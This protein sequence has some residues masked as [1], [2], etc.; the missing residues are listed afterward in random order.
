MGKA[1]AN[2]RVAKRK[3]VEQI[4]VTNITTLLHFE[5]IAEQ[6]LLVDASSSGFLMHINR[7]DLVPE[8]LRSNLNISI[9]EGEPV[10]MMISQMELEL[11]GKIART[12]YI[13]KGVFEVAVDFSDD[14]PEYW[15]ECLFDLL[16]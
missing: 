2:K 9:V 7:K 14:A 3:S 12:K 13:G 6:A 1:A 5:K 15:R 16:S 11:N 8:H 4:S 10:M